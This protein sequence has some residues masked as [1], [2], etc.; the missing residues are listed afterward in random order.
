MFFKIGLLKNFAIFREKHLCW[1]LFLIKL[2]TFRTFPVN[3]TK[4]LT[5]A[6]F[7][8]LQRVAA[9]ADVLLTLKTLLNS[10]TLH[11]CS[12][13]KPKIT[14]ICFHLLSFYVPLVVIHCHSFAHVVIHC[15]WLSFVVTHCHSLYHSLLFIVTCCHSLSLD[16]SLAC[17]FINDRYT[18]LFEFIYWRE[19]CIIKYLQNQ[20]K[21]IYF[22]IDSGMCLDLIKFFY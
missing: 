2:Q 17:L 1:S 14:L 18:L 8:E 13:L 10:Y 11:N 16:V 20:I 5:V 6:F 22:I 7:I 15:H 3:I 12:I 21:T 4:F 19:K 9:S